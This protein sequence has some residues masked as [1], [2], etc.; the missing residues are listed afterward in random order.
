MRHRPVLSALGR[1]L[2]AAGLVLVAL[3]PPGAAAAAPENPPASGDPRAVASPGNAV[4]CSDVS[5]AGELVDLA[6]TVDESR[7]TLDVTGLPEGLTVTGV[8]VKGGPAYNSYLPSALGPLPW[9]GLH[10]PVNP[11]G[12]PAQISHWFACAQRTAP[13]TPRPTPLMV[14][15]TPAAP[16]PTGAVPNPAPPRTMAPHPGVTPTDALPPAPAGSAIATPSAP[17][18]PSSSSTVQA[19][20]APRDDAGNLASTGFDGGWL[21]PVGAL[22]LLGGGVAL[23]VPRVRAGLRRRH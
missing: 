12:K 20:P 18:T 9:R 21:I 4:K 5:L 14:V 15:P 3:A 6:H 1:A 16:P 19:A 17:S 8:V 2:T 22:L 7:A 10:A 11:S 13:T 23:A